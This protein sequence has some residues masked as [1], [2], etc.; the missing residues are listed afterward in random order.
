M[1]KRT[2]L[3]AL[4]LLV[5]ARLAAAQ[6]A[7][8]A[9]ATEL[10]NS[11][12]D[13]MEKGNFKEACPKLAESARL[14][15]KV[16]TLARLGECEEKLGHL[17][18]SRASWQQAA[19]LARSTNDRRAAHVEEELGR[20]DRLVPKVTIALEGAAGAPDVKVTL[21]DVAIGAASL[22]LALP[23]GPGSHT[24]GV[25]ASGKKSWS[26]RFDA[27]PEVK[28]TVTVPPLAPEES[29]APAPVPAPL[30]KPEPAR[31]E[32]PPAPPPAD[33][34]PAGGASQRTAGLVTGGVGIVGLGLGALFALEAISN[35]DDSSSHC[36]DNTCDVQGADSRGTARTF[37]NAATTS[38][39][40]GGVALAGGAALYLGAPREGE[41]PGLLSQKNVGLAMGA[42]GVVSLGIG[43]VYALHAKSKNDDSGVECA[44]N[45]CS[46]D[47]A[48]LRRD[49]VAAGDTAT[50]AF[51]SG[52]ALIAGA[53]LLWLTASSSSIAL[54]PAIGSGSRAI[55]IQGRW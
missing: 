11:G 51:V 34:R 35:N 27:K 48:E 19:N 29:A 30:A 18:E 28:A 40:V 8:S 3:L 2:S 1:T 41:R 21:D 12:R 45:R 5:C 15:A 22:G 55:A 32:E 9:L 24:I 42:I 50:V 52:G 13:L 39:L 20:I 6:S 14:D 38:F 26:T 17:V 54:S 37:G 49:A 53:G 43:A 33:S 16:G 46:P 25:T 47:G 44:N 36:S 4:G 31:A 10:F 7:G 23:I